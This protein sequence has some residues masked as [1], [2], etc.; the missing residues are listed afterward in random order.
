MLCLVELGWVGLGWVGLWEVLCSLLVVDRFGQTSVVVSSGGKEA[1]ALLVFGGFGPAPAAHGRL[2]DL[3]KL[4]LSG[5]PHQWC[6]HSSDYHSSGCGEAPYLQAFP[7]TLTVCVSP[8]WAHVYPL[9]I[10][11]P[12]VNAGATS[13]SAVCCAV[14]GEG[15]GETVGGAVQPPCVHA[16]MCTCVLVGMV[17]WCV[18]HLS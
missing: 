13:M 4:T 17:G 5:T 15:P 1:D 14:E 16:Y 7:I 12:A 11:S 9:S 6:S 18:G 2:G 3:V 10:L 8:S